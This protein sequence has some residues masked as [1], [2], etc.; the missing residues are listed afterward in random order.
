VAF[1]VG[2]N[3]FTITDARASGG[4]LSP[5]FQTIEEARNFFDLGY[6]DGKPYPIGGGLVIQLPKSLL[7]RMSRAEVQAKI[8]AILPL[9]TLPVIRYYDN[10]GVESL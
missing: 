5:Q 6:W 10:T 3:D 7:D 8:N 4:G 1:E 2:T 9:G